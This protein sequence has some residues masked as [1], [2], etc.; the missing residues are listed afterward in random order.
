MST[1]QDMAQAPRAV[2]DAAVA[3]PSEVYT[4][5]WNALDRLFNIGAFYPPGHARCVE[6][7]QALRDE[8]A[9][10]RG[11]AAGVRIDAGRDALAVQG[12][13]DGLESRG[14][15]RLH[16]T[17]DALA[18]ARLEF[19]ADV[20]AEDLHAFAVRLL[21]C[22]HQVD[23][24]V[25]F[26][27]VD[28]EGLPATVR[29][30]QREFGRRSGGGGLSLRADQVD[31][32]VTDILQSL[33]ERGV[34]EAQREECRAIFSRFFSRVAERLE[35]DTPPAGAR[36]AFA[37]PLEEVL[38]LGV[39]AVQHALTRVLPQGGDL[40]DVQRLFEQTQRA[41]ALSEDRDSVELLVDVLAEVANREGGCAPG[42]L[43]PALDDADSRYEIGVPAL[44]RLLATALAAGP[45][46]ADLVPGDLT[47]ALSVALTLLL[48]SPS[49]A[50]AEAARARLVADLARPLRAAERAVVAGALA[51]LSARGDAAAADRLLPALLA[52]LRGHGGGG[53]AVVLVQACRQGRP[54]DLRVL[55]P[56]LVNE[57]LLGLADAPEGAARDLRSLVA[58]LPV[59]EM[60]QGLRRLE[61]LPALR[62]GDLDRRVFASPDPA[63][64]PLLGLLLGTS[65]G[66][67]VGAAL[68]EALQSRPP[69]WPGAAALPL[70]G[71]YHG[72]HRGLL[73]AWLREA[74]AGR[75]TADL[76]ADLA[77]LLA[78]LPTLAP[79]RRREPWVPAALRAWAEF[80]GAAAAP[81]LAAIVRER[82][83][84]FLRAW[85]EPCRRAAA[86]AAR[87]LAAAAPEPA[88]A[89]A[90]DAP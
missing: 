21:W 88:P 26:R 51:G 4:A 61:A 77:R 5:L 83:L 50:V 24:A 44:K 2:A 81:G 74:P 34:G 28:F 35:L 37:R 36:P 58:A 43:A 25:G 31:Q 13:L 80:G 15:Q 38:S 67:I 17:M 84:L 89:A 18:I 52:A 11:G 86:E 78:A 63:L 87:A 27:Q 75:L 79:A 54:A 1:G 76:R 55:W 12:R 60:R 8:L 7:A 72:R 22:K 68:L 23:T 14:A 49:P 66:E 29:V 85:P 19:A 16:A 6:V 10:L 53:A 46:A 57:L 20:S 32:A 64:G 56:H 3:P 9:Q 70:L 71:A 48:D 30:A 33:A 69:S 41:I 42:S 62:D 45:P 47:E 39:H 40:V 65:R 59:E 82:R 90:G 73:G